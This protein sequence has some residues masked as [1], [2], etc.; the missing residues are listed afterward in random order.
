MEKKI[1]TPLSYRAYIYR[2]D[3]YIGLLSWGY[4]EIMEKEMETTIGF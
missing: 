2:L 4:I 3:K 1:E